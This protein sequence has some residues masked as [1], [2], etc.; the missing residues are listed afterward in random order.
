[1]VRHRRGATTPTATASPPLGFFHD[2][3]GK[4]AMA[5]TSAGQPIRYATVGGRTTAW[6][7]NRSAMTGASSGR[8]A[9]AHRRLM[10]PGMRRSAEHEG[11][12]RVFLSH[13]R[14]DCK[15][16]E[17]QGHAQTP[18]DLFGRSWPIT[19]PTPRPAPEV[20][21]EGDP[22]SDLFLLLWTRNSR[23]SGWVSQEIGMAL[24]TVG[25]SFPSWSS[26][27]CG[28]GESTNGRAG[29]SVR[30]EQA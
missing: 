9:K 1:V 20:D 17:H 27:G 23:L 21:R 29:D 22:T 15:L 16:P 7:P 14:A 6:V 3:W 13:N 5:M 10:T 18:G 28:S 8:R 24:A 4:K 2:R 30:Q 19:R 25:R 12:Y 11:P 26:H